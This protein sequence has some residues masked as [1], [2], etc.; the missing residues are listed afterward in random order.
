EKTG[1][2]GLRGGDILLPDFKEQYNLL[3]EKHDEI[4]QQFGQVLDVEAMEA[5]WFEGVETLR[6]LQIVSTE[7]YLNNALLQG[8]KVLAEGA[9]GSML[10]IDFGTYPFVTSSNTIS[11]GACKG[12]GIAPN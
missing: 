5:D 3:R 1:R 11:S 7:Y 10:D 2:N 8:K 4:I 12:L 9:Q 6:Q